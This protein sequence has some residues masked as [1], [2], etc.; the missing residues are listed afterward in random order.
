MAACMGTVEIKKTAV[1]TYAHL[2]TQPT[3]RPATL[4]G[5]CDRFEILLRRYS[6][7]ASELPPRFQT[8]LASATECQRT[9]STLEAVCTQLFC[10][11]ICSD[12]SSASGG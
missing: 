7:F 8:W 5:A 12:E 2:V 3:M 1:R 11:G 6:I 10:Y 4:E 9:F